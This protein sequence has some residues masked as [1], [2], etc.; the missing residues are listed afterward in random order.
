MVYLAAGDLQVAVAPSHDDVDGEPAIEGLSLRRIAWRRLKRDR[1]AVVGGCVL[2][3]IVLIA[4]FSSQLNQLYGQEPSTFH[5]NLTSRDA[6]VAARLVRWNLGPAL[7]RRR[8][9]QWP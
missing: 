6:S 3:L 2:L 7:A 1:V 5:S 8:T 9:D 4:A